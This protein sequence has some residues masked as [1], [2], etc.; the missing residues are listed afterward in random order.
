M[1]PSR[2]RT[3]LALAV[4]APLVAACN[5]STGSGECRAVFSGRVATAEGAPV[6]N[7][8]VALRD[9]VTPGGVPLL[10]ATSDATGNYGAVLSGACL[11]CGATV[12]PPAQYQLPAGAPARLPAPL[13]CNET[14][15]VNFTLAR[16]SDQVD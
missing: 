9:T 4:L 12:T 1:I 5:D 13:Q 6:P 2:M 14:L 15:E 10:T 11:T 3:A 7:A 8:S 16:T